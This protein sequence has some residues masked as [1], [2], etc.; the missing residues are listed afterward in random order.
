[1]KGT[2]PYGW[3]YSLAQRLMAG[4][5]NLALVQASTCLDDILFYLVLD[6][7]TNP[8]N[9]F[10]SWTSLICAIVFLVSGC[11]LILFNFWLVKRYQ[12]V[13]HQG[14]I[15]R[16]NKENLE[17]FNEKNRYWELFYPDFNENDLWSQSFFA[18]F[19]IQSTLSS[20]I[21]AI[22]YDY[23]LMQTPFLVTLDGVIILLFYFKNPLKTL[24]GKL[25]QWFFE[26]KTL[27]VHILTFILSLRDS[28]EKPPES[29]RD[30]LSTGIIYLNTALVA[31][32]LGFM[33]IEIHETIKAK[34]KERQLKWRQNLSNE[35][36]GN[37]TRT[38]SPRKLQE[39][40]TQKRNTGERT[41][42]LKKLDLSSEYQHNNSNIAV[43]RVNA[44]PFQ[45]LDSSFNADNSFVSN[46]GG[47]GQR[48]QSIMPIIQR[49]LRV[50]KSQ[51]NGSA[52]GD[53]DKSS[54]QLKETVKI[55][56]GQELP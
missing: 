1:L 34:I 3:A 43:F 27:L 23:P 44:E 11:L 18:T 25:A 38:S 32:S 33:F 20:L 50:F 19:I 5:F 8:F 28:L 48:D 6:A 4:S 49:K 37:L 42:S 53:Q 22:F 52:I 47:N 46:M 54:K 10:F 9:S 35:E 26:T 51:R 14:L 17:V 29:L 41:S 13:K 30:T 12:D 24:R 16:E 55:S 7:K 36:A 21:I 45:G 15:V 2:K 56:Q 40:E 39:A 31:G